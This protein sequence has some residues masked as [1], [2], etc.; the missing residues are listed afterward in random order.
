MILCG[1]GSMQLWRTEAGVLTNHSENL[2]CQGLASLYSP[3]AG[4]WRGQKGPEWKASGFDM[5][6][7]GR[8]EFK[9]GIN[10]KRTCRDSPAHG[11]FDHHLQN[12][13]QCI[14]P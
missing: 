14:C 9:Y 2:C 5:G 10:T 11:V 13:E 8:H 12:V 3:S 7:S 6:S 4:P 1:V